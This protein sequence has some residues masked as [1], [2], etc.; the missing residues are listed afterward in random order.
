MIL[1][2]L[3]E[4]IYLL[5]GDEKQNLLFV[6]LHIF[7]QNSLGVSGCII[8]HWKYIFKENTAP[9][10]SW[11]MV[12][13]RKCWAQANTALRGPRGPRGLRALGDKP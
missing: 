1:T 3:F 8:H 2:V 6:C 12:H 11:K 7:P 4:F 9:L 5:W 13:I 10:E